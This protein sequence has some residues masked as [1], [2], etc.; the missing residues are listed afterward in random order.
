LADS[1]RLGISTIH[2]IIKEVCEAIWKTLAPLHMPVSTKQMLLATSNEFY[3]KLNFPNCVGSIDAKHIRLK[4]PSNSGSMY[5]NYKHYYSIVLQGLADARHRFIAID[6]GASGKQSDGGIFRHRS[7]YQ[8]LISNNFNM[9]NAKKL[10]LSDLELPFVILGDKAYPLLSYLMR[11]Y[12]RRQLTESRRFFNYRLYRIRGVA[13]SAFGILAGKWRILNKP[14]ETSPNMADRIVKCICVL[15]STVIGREG[16]DE[17]SLL[18]LQNQEDSFSTNLDEPE[19]QATRSTNRTH[20]RARRVRDAFTVYF[21][22]DVG[23]LPENS[24]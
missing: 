14:M 5:Y 4:C 15:H 3:L 24:H 13:E 2:Y 11:P 6:V 16:L 1:F 19:R 12:P 7:L 20:L 17:A 9:P 21:K 8:L 23:R 22:S 18:A 10:P